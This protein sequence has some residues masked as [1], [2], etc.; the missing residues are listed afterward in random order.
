MPDQH[1]LWAG[2]WKLFRQL[3]AHRR[4]QFYG[5]MLLLVV[6][7]L[8]E[9]ATIGIV[10]PFLAL[11][12]P[13]ETDARAAAAVH[14]LDSFAMQ[15]GYSRLAVATAVLIFVALASAGLSL[16]LTW[17]MYKFVF[18][19]ARDLRF[20]AVRPYASPV[21]RLSRDA[22]LKSHDLG[23]GEG[24]ARPCLR[25]DPNDPGADCFW[26]GAVRDRG[27]G[28]ACPRR[29]GR[30]EHDLRPS[31]WSDRVCYEGAHRRQFAPP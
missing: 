12:I 16:L 27:H 14:F 21:S 23:S 26:S 19:A 11:I 9:L 13:G 8:A 3:P 29:R 22:Q 7:G 17:S 31:P 5:T 30:R 24:A 1:S 6:G 15:T 20:S 25:A 28:R 10:F 18:R 4:R 2:V